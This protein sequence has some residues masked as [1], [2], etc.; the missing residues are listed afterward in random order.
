MIS[1]PLPAVTPTGRNDHVARSAVPAVAAATARNSSGENGRGCPVSGALSATMT[2]CSDCGYGNG[3]NST[4][5]TTL[6]AAVFAPVAIAR[7]ALAAIDHPGRAA[8]I[9]T[10]YRTSRPSVSSHCGGQRPETG[11][12]FRSQIVVKPLAVPGSERREPRQKPSHRS[13]DL[14]P[15]NLAT[16]TVARSHFAVSNCTCFF[17]ARVSP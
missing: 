11:A 7:H 1:A 2:N 5:L 12:H 4:A 6:K 3:R 17:P 9:R 10:A 13:H 15:T 14:A 8:S 16:R